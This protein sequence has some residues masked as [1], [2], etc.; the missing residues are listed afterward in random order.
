MGGFVPLQQFCNWQHNLDA[1]QQQAQLKCCVKNLTLP[2]IKMDF[3]LFTTRAHHS[4]TRANTRTFMQPGEKASPCTHSS[5]HHPGL[6]QPH[7]AMPHPAPA[8]DQTSNRAQPHHP[9]SAPELT[10]SVSQHRKLSWPWVC[11]NNCPV[12]GSKTG[13]SFS[14]PCSAMLLL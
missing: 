2:Q 9:N 13:L 12:Y 11:P 8:P 10:N 14:T 6:I 5:K 4:P 3:A 1:K 7:T